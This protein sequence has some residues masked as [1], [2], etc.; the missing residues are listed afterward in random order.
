MGPTAKDSTAR[1]DIASK[2]LA[3]ETSNR[4][5]ES[6]RGNRVNEIARANRERNPKPLIQY[7]IE[8]LIEFLVSITTSCSCC[9][10]SFIPETYR[11]PSLCEH[12]RIIAIRI[13]QMTTPIAEGR[14]NKHKDAGICEL[15]RM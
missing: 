8:Y 3:T 11:L 4:S 9:W 12:I 7:L 1:K 10:F 15:P 5:Y 13:T 14:S 6:Q 2:R